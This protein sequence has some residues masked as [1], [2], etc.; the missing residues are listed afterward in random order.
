MFKIQTNSSSRIEYFKQ[1]YRLYME[2][3]K[4][5]KN[6]KY[7]FDHILFSWIESKNELYLH[8]TNIHCPIQINSHFI[9]NNIYEI[10]VK[11]V[12]IYRLYETNED[13]DK[14]YGTDYYGI[15]YEENRKITQWKCFYKPD[16]SEKIEQYQLKKYHFYELFE[17][18]GMNQIDLHISYINPYKGF[19]LFY[20]HQNKHESSFIYTSQNTQNI[21]NPMI[22]NFYR[23]YMIESLQPYISQQF[24][25]E[26]NNIH[27]SSSLFIEDVQLVQNLLGNRY[28]DDIPTKYMFKIDSFSFRTCI[29]I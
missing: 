15:I 12:P 11:N 16:F 25:I 19:D 26:N 9:E 5:D 4:Y 13:D 24:Y 21:E 27:H 29:S 7:S 2:N 18:L 6:I 8:H 22:D 14:I 20:T 17:L 1:K 10:E 3:I 28:S 23:E